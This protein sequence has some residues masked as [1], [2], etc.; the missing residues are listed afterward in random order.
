MTT[1][2]DMIT[3]WYGKIIPENEEQRKFMLGTGQLFELHSIDRVIDDDQVLK[4]I[5]TKFP[6]D[7][8]YSDTL[9]SNSD[10]FKKPNP[11]SELQENTRVTIKLAYILYPREKYKIER[12]RRRRRESSKL[13]PKR[14][15]LKKQK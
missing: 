6:A 3:G 4:E 8:M 11:S 7:K 14:D 1:E 13:H 5:R 12:E 2:A 15:D 9:L 10:M